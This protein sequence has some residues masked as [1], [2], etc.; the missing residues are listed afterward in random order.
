MRVRLY[1]ALDIKHRSLSKTTIKYLQSSYQ[2]FYA[3][4]VRYSIANG[5]NSRFPDARARSPHTLPRV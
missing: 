3:S 5:M 2:E 4:D 1:E